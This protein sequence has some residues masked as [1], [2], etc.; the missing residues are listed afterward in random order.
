MMIGQN[1]NSVS[2]LDKIPHGSIGAEIGV[3]KGDSSELFLKKTNPLELHL[4]DP[5]SFDA[6]SINLSEEEYKSDIEKYSRLTNSKDKKSFETYYDSIYKGVIRRFKD[7]DNV[8]IHRKTSTEWFNNFDKKLDWIYIDGDHTYI[9][10][11]NDLTNCLRVMKSNGIIFGDDYG[12][13][14]DVKKAVDDFVKTKNF[15]FAILGKNQFMIKV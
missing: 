9:G 15:S 13:K 6:F 10:C 5:W 12:N 4:V 11:L 2:I 1:T 7:Y 14:P 3:W 8:I